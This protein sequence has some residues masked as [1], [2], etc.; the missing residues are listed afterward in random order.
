M[1]PRVQEF[2]DKLT[3]EEKRNLLKHFCEIDL[4][5]SYHYTLEDYDYQITYLAWLWAHGWVYEKGK[6]DYY[7]D[8]NETGLPMAA[9]EMPPTIDTMRP[10]NLD[11]LCIYLEYELDALRERLG[12]SQPHHH[13]CPVKLLAARFSA[14]P[15]NDSSEASGDAS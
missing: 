12:W 5:Q 11:L 13:P 8:E 4:I 3:H 15:D 10:Y 1:Y 2:T 14:G 7:Y 9:F 6:F